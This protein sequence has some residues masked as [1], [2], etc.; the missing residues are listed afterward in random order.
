MDG[1][2]KYPQLKIIA[3]GAAGTA[4]DVVEY[5]LEMRNHVSEIYVPLMTNEELRLVMSKG[6][7]ALNCEFG[8]LVT[9][10]IVQFSSGLAAVCHQL[11]LNA[12]FAANIAKTQDSTLRFSDSHIER[13]IQRYL[14]DSSDTLKSTFDRATKQKRKGKYD[15]CQLI[16]HALSALDSDGV[17]HNDLLSQIQNDVPDS[18]LL[19]SGFGFLNSFFAHLMRSD[20]FAVRNG[21]MVYRSNAEI[22]MTPSTSWI[23]GSLRKKVPQ[24]NR[25]Y[26]H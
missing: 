20:K 7:S 11:C 9:Q 12:C 22:K 2:D 13:A 23:F 3:I 16:V 18:E 6:E 14:D 24:C 25:Y 21:W 4:R 17:S 1:A 10:D 19:I 8:T 5:D 26:C 15:N